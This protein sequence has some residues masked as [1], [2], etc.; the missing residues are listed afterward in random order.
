MRFYTYTGHF[1]HP[2]GAPSLL[3]I[4]VS[5]SREC[6]Y[7]GSGV[8]WWP[9]AL[10]TFVVADLLPAELK[11]HGL[12]HDASECVLGDIPKPAKTYAIEQMEKELLDA[13]Y[14]SLALVQLSPD[15]AEQ[16]HQADR[17]VLHGEVWTVGTQ[18]LRQVYP[19]DTEAME[20]VD[21]YARCFPVEDCVGGENAPC[22][23]E[24]L[25]RFEVYAGKV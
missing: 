16:V 11:V 8:A 24:F 9:V 3:D 17:R 19:H 14:G 25:R 22:V 1:D 12:L 6:R 13:I 18:S 2:G 10:H 5:L 4:A 21:Y 23:K 7:A 15:D 20:L